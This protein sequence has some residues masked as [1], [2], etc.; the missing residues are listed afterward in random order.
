MPGLGQVGVG[1]GPGLHGPGFMPAGPH[2][3]DALSQSV[4]EVYERGAPQARPP[5]Q[6]REVRAHRGDQVERAFEAELNEQDGLATHRL[7]LTRLEQVAGDLHHL[8]GATRHGGGLHPQQLELQRGFDVADLHFDGPALQIQRVDLRAGIALRVQQRGDQVDRLGLAVAPDAFGSDI[9]QLQRL[10][11]RVPLLLAQ[12]GFAAFG[13]L[14]PHH[15][16]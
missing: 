1:F 8:H 10:G 14:A 4:L 9:T 2:F 13:G 11:Q 12:A 6:S 15:F 3:D 5:G 7:G 16:A